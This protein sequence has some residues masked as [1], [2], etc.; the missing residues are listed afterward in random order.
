M[1]VIGGADGPT[2]IVV[3]GWSGQITGFYGKGLAMLVICM[4]IAYFLGNISP[5]TILG[6]FHGID[7]KK[8]G[9]GNAGTTNALRVL[10]KKAAVI[11]LIIDIG[12]GVLAVLLGRY[13]GAYYAMQCIDANLMN[14]ESYTAFTNYVAN[15][16]G[17]CCGLMVFIGHIWPMLLKFK[18]GKGVATA[19]GVLVT[20]NPLMG[21]AT[22]GVVAI[23]VLITRMVSAGSVCGAI[24]LPFIAHFLMPQFVLPGGVMAIIVIIK[25]RANIKRILNKTESRLF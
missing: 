20:L 14:A 10:G 6:K 16:G 22:L 1:G 25:H 11:T 9:S 13:V 19:F 23:V 4:I 12:K 3:A 5:A 2:A 15:F 8:A 21:L 18:G 17:I 7:I 24:A